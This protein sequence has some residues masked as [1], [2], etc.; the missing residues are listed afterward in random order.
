MDTLII[1]VVAIAGIAAFVGLLCFVSWGVDRV[2][3]EYIDY[4]RKGKDD[5]SD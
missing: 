4:A 5:G 3:K 1:V 2:I